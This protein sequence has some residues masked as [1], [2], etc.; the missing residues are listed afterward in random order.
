MFA[1]RPY[2]LRCCVVVCVLVC[3]YRCAIVRVVASL[4]ACLYVYICVRLLVYLIVR[5]FIMRACVSVHL[6][7]CR[8]VWLIVV[9]LRVCLCAW[10][11]DCVDDRKSGC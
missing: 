10:L 5:F 8:F 9:R 7:A 2:C 3:L 11:C 1:H 6:F 4:S